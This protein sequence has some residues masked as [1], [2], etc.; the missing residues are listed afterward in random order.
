MV[1]FIINLGLF[2]TFAKLM[3]ELVAKLFISI[4]GRYCVYMFPSEAAFVNKWVVV[5]LYNQ[6]IG[7]QRI[8]VV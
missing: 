4:G 1:Y 7:E 5:K 6:L 3:C 8:V 2:P